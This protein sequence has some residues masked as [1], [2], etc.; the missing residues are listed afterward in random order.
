ALTYR[1]GD[2]DP[3]IGGLIGG[4][5]GVCLGGRRIGTLGYW[6][7]MCTAVATLL[8]R[9]PGYA[10]ELLFLTAATSGFVVGRVGGLVETGVMTRRNRPMQAPGPV[11][12]AP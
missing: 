5:W 12:R 9:L 6:G 1:W 10:D 2:A 3:L 8:A 4:L 11:E 7:A